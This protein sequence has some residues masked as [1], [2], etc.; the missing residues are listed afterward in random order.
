MVTMPSTQT[1][2]PMKED[3]RSLGVTLWKPKGPEKPTITR[4]PSFKNLG[5][6]FLATSDTASDAGCMYSPGLRITL[7]TRRASARSKPNRR[8]G[9]RK[10]E[11]AGK[12]GE[13]AAAG[14]CGRGRGCDFGGRPCR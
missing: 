8:S 5:S 10:N 3:M 9:F 14:T 4:S 7:F 12:K 1:M 11:R 13:A 2:V 6:R